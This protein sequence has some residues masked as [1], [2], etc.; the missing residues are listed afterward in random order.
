MPIPVFLLTD[1]MLYAVVAVVLGFAAYARRRDHLR[2]PWRIVARS[3]TAVAALVVLGFYAAVGLLDS[4]H[5]RP[6]GAPGPA[7]AGAAPSAEVLSLLDVLLR[8]L[9]EQKEKTYSAPLATHLHGMGFHRRAQL[10]FS[11]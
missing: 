3:R 5:F 10:G 6:V 9:R 4:V 8:P 1:L 11:E 2:A 7:G